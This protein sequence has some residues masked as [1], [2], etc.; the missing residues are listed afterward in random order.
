VLEG[1]FENG[2]TTRWIFSDIT[3][4]SFSWRSVDSSDGFETWTLHQE[5]KARRKLPEQRTGLRGRP[6]ALID[7][8]TNL[9]LRPPA[10]GV[11]PGVYKLPGAL[12]DNGLLDGLGAVDGGVV[13][14]PRYSAAWQPSGGVRNEAAIARYSSKLAD[15]LER[16]LDGGFF[17]VV[18]GG[19][20]SVLI[21]D[22]LALRRRG[23]FGL[24]FID[25]HSDF[26]HLGNSEVVGSA[27][28]EDLAIVTGRGGALASIESRVPLVLDEDVVLFGVRDDDP[29]LEEIR[30]TAMSVATAGD[31]ARLGPASVAT[32]ALA[33]LRSPELSGF[34][35]HCDFDVL[36][37]SVMPAVDTPEPA[38]LDFD[39]LVELLAPLLADERA[40]GVEFTIFDPDLDEE[41]E[42]AA[43]IT[44]SLLR[45]FTD[46]TAIA[47]QR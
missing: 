13:V 14:A 23:R 26:R 43:K 10:D 41:G 25:G 3:S 44:A 31:I 39:T 27:A 47:T 7:A 18:L 21:G 9:G 38:G 46:A 5:M 33:R 34:W 1:S 19:D 2:V 40:A 4:E 11:A 15:R 20:C 22:Q 32:R 36:D 30:G 8:P 35:I 6:L 45:A 37:S 16:L 28:G 42:L 12:R 24:A 29:L 17:P